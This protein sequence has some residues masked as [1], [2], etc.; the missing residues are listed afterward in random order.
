M[1]DSVEVWTNNGTGV[2]SFNAAYGDNEGIECVIAADV[3][4]DGKPDLV[5][6]NSWNN[7]VNVLTNNGAGLFV[8]SGTNTVGPA[9]ISVAAV[10]VNGDGAL[11][12]VTANYGNNIY[13]GISL[14]VLT[15]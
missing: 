14:T 4:G 8:L 15:E 12:L 7:S 10:D 3:N 1:G 6:V 9:P 5:Y 13:D 11:D 2:F